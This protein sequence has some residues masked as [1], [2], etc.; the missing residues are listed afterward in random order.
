[1]SKTCKGCLAGCELKSS[2]KSFCVGKKRI[3]YISIS[4]MAKAGFCKN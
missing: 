4:K 3:F 2:L 1:M